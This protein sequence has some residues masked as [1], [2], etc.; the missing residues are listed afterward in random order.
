[1]GV[2]L[3][4]L[5]PKTIVAV[6]GVLGIVLC[7]Y[8]F[9]AKPHFAGTRAWSAAQHAIAQDRLD[10]A[11]RHVGACLD[12]WPNDPAV[13]LLAIRI[14]RLRGD[15]QHAGKHLKECDRLLQGTM[16]ERL[17]LEWCL[18]WAQTED[19]AEVEPGLVS[20][21]DKG[22]LQS[23]LIME[24]LALAYMKEYRFKAALGC[25]TKWLEQEPD[26]VRALHWRGWARENLESQREAVEDYEQ[27]L[28]LV[29]DHLKARTRLVELLLAEKKTPE[30]AQH[31]KILEE[32]HGEADRL[33]LL[34]ARCLSLEGKTVEA[35]AILDEFLASHAGNATA[36]YERGQIEREPVS[37]EPYFRAALKR[38]PV[39]LEVRFALYTCLQAQQRRHE[40]AQELERYRTMKADAELL[41]KALEKLNAQPRDPDL[42]AQVG[43]LMLKTGN[44]KMGRFLLG[45]ALSA[46]RSSGSRPVPQSPGP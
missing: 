20:R 7:G 25:L 43:E 15:F 37:Q 34:R 45:R 24:A 26:N 21:L 44:E 10:D 3:T 30:A 2:K 42:L 8:L 11:R 28:S 38:K 36:L 31:L 18:F 46:R 23:S 14:A 5:R 22:D 35:K 39:F 12:V 41:K 16:N 1:L 33:P 29:P 40:A 4:W 17:Q 32:N 13:H 6:V 9:W 19:L 27:V